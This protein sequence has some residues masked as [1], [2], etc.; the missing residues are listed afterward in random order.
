MF[1]TTHLAPNIMICPTIALGV[2]LNPN[3]LHECRPISLTLMRI[4]EKNQQITYI[5][6]S[7]DPVSNRLTKWTI[8]EYGPPFFSP[9]FFPIYI[10]YYQIQKADR[11]AIRDTDHPFSVPNHK[12]LEK[13]TP[14]AKKNH[15]HFYSLMGE[16]H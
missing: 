4:L 15:S 5:G 1:F 14:K 11:P 9:N 16:I 8:P 6:Y 12:I 13:Q 7:G 10:K 3:I 2:I